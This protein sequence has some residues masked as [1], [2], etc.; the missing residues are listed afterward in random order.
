MEGYIVA[1]FIDLKVFD[2]MDK[3]VLGETMRKKEVREELIKWM[4]EVV[5]ETKSR[6]RSGEK[7][8]KVLDG[9]GMRQGD[10]R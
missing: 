9:K 10:V 5:R 7:I 1:M 3:K 2:L 4:E 6:V 8:G